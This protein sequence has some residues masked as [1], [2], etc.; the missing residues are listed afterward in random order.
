MSQFTTLAR[1][2]NNISNNNNNNNNNDNNNNIKILE[3][4][5]EKS[6]NA[7]FLF[8]II[9]FLDVALHYQVPTKA[10]NFLTLFNCDQ[11]Y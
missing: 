6:S 8:I 2:S 3:F 9:S 5:K 7:S 4:S 11:I 10:N 1:F